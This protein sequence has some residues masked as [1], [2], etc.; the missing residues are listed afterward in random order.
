VATSSDSSRL[1]TLGFKLAEMFPAP[2]VCRIYARA[3][4]TSPLKEVWNSG[5]DEEFVGMDGER[6]LGTCEKR[7][8]TIL[9]RDASTDPH[10]RGVARRK[11]KSCLCVPVF[12]DSKHLIG[13]IYLSST[14]AE[15]FTTHSQIT[16]EKMAT[17]FTPVLASLNPT[18][19]PKKVE[20]TGKGS[21]EFLY[22]PT[23]IV[24]GLALVLV[25]SL[26]LL[27]PTPAG[28]PEPG[29]G[30]QDGKV[31]VFGP[32][33]VTQTF[34]QHLRV[35]EYAQAWE[36]FDPVLQERWP[37]E[38]FQS[39]LKEW[40]QSEEHQRILLE[41]KLSGL[42]R[43]EKR[44]TAVFYGSSVEGDSEPWNWELREFDDRWGIIWMQGGPVQ[45]PGQKL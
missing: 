27:A 38:D 15:T 10:L 22:S 20:K 26:M 24:L 1:N 16:I 29:S 41:R 25:G 19:L 9:V 39:Q 7:R 42:K 23:T 28:I 35:G 34:A 2:A 18:A 45:S 12:D 36:L 31:S 14:S 32:R 40:S 44:A 37:Q 5:P 13:L 8:L 17:E 6:I 4:I 33:E 3:T 30:S 21:F 11:F 43:L